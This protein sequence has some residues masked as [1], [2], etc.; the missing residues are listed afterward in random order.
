MF[1]HTLD[2][3]LKFDRSINRHFLIFIYLKLMNNIQSVIVNML[4]GKAVTIFAAFL[5]S[6]T[7]ANPTNSNWNLIDSL[8]Y[9]DTFPVYKY[10]SQRTGMTLTL[11][12]PES[13]MVSGYFCLATEA[14]DD[15]GI[16]HDLEHLIFQGS[17]DYPYQEIL[18]LLAQRCLSS[19]VNAW[20]ARDHTC[21][22]VTTAGSDGFLTIMPIF[23]EHIFHPTLNDVDYV[24]EIHHINKDGEDAGVVYSEM[25]G[26]E[27]SWWY[28]SYQAS[29]RAMYGADS[30]YAA[31]TG[32]AV[33][34]LR[35]S[36]SNEKVRAYHAKYYRPGNM[37]LV[38]YGQISPEEIFRALEPV[39]RKLLDK[40]SPLELD[41]PTRPFS[42]VAPVFDSDVNV[43]VAFPASEAKTG[44]MSFS[45]HL[46][47]AL[48]D[49]I[50]LTKAVSFLGGYLA[51]DA[52]SPLDKTFVNVAEP[53]ASYVYCWANAKARPTVTITLIS[54]PVDKMDQI[55][56]KL[57]V[58]LDEVANG[59]FDLAKMR[60]ICK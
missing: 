9:E 33:A 39:E 30:S 38:I 58:A 40:G 7:A 47:A 25:K 59:N 3:A 55:E 26:V 60:T 34:N 15:D 4:T 14:F 8:Q 21:Y 18:Q 2:R 19:H 46:P 54:V 51:Y 50:D 52:T 57:R 53:L 43:E 13:P 36:T 12:Q 32:G 48:W 44:H 45:W 42:T 16:P 41:L 20:T 28:L 29:M 49:D 1:Q 5:L 56:D 35:N 22:M 31:N 11:T 6:P 27:K 10:K 17:E 24:T 37:N 23:L